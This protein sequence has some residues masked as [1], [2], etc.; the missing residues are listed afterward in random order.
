MASWTT[1]HFVTLRFP[2]SFRHAQ[3][4]Q[5]FLLKLATFCKVSAG[6]WQHQQVF[7]FPDFRS[8]LAVPSSSTSFFSPQ[9]FFQIWQELSPLFSFTIRLKWVPGHSFLPG[10]DLADKL[11]RLG[12]LLVP[13]AIPRS[14]SPLTSHFL[15]SFLS[16]WWHTVSSKFF[17]ILLP[18][19]STEELVL[20]RHSRC[21]LCRL[22]CNGRSL[23]FSSYLSRIGRIENSSCCACGHPSQDTFH[24][25][26]HCPATD[27]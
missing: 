2:F 16:D 14:L 12:A 27:S 13:F 26:L 25:I 15:F 7:P 5:V 6:L 20:P 11:V 3:L 1:T 22:R 9:T 10:N 24:L 4:V 23:L 17:D 19:I 8:V 18:S 21:V